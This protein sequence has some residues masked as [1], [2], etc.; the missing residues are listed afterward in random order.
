MKTLNALMGA[1]IAAVIVLTSLVTGAAAATADAGSGP[2]TVDSEVRDGTAYVAVSGLQPLRDDSTLAVTVWHED[3]DP[4]APA[5][6][7]ILYTNAIYLQG[8]SSVAIEVPLQGQDPERLRLSIRDDQGVS[9]Y[10][11]GLLVDD[12]EVTVPD[13]PAAPTIDQAGGTVAVSWTAPAD[14]GSPIIEYTVVIDGT[15]ILTAAGDATSLDIGALSAGA[16]TARVIAVNSVGASAS[17]PST[18]FTVAGTGE[19]TPQPTDDATTPT[20]PT[21]DNRGTV[22]V[23]EAAYPGQSIAVRVGGAWSGERVVIWLDETLVAAVELDA[24]GATRVTIPVDT[25]LG[26]ARISVTDVDGVLIGWDGIVITER[27]R[28]AADGTL[29]PPTGAS[30]PVIALVI[31]VLLLAAGGVFVAARRRVAAPA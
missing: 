12:I 4:A 19:S 31:A 8:R 10:Q 20:D 21:D 14:G 28:V 7:D 2:L 17:S 9:V 23:P 5:P 29:L 6:G 30:L 3:A 16:H 18:Q 11:G 1:V 15:Q 26:D 13:A 27:E 22:S 24:T 25:R